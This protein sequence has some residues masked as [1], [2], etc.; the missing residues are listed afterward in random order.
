[1]P[2]KEVPCEACKATGNCLKCVET[3]DDECED[4]GGSGVCP[5]CGGEKVV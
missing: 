3:F 1:M 5:E 4:C 2:K